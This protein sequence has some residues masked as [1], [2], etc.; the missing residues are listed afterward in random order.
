[1]RR[2]AETAGG[3]GAVVTALAALLG[4]STETV[5]AVGVIAGVLP[6]GVT[7]VVSNGGVAGL[8]WRFW[9]GR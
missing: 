8:W 9:R 3:L 7:W 2:P 6:G 5:A 1:M 4:A